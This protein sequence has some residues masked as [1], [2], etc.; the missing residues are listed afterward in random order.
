MAPDVDDRLAG[1]VV[2]VLFAALV[3]RERPDRLYFRLGSLPNPS[4]LRQQ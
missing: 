2:D 4:I 3:A 1:A